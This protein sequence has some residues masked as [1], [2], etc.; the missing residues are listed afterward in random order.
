MNNQAINY[1][2]DINSSTE[3]RIYTIEERMD[4]YESKVNQI[5]YIQIAS[6][7]LFVITSPQVFNI[8]KLIGL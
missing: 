6:I 7:M 8:L 2:R 5:L 1:Q 4:K 3:R